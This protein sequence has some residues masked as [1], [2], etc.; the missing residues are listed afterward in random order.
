M[1]SQFIPKNLIGKNDILR[2]E[3]FCQRR[4]QSVLLVPYLS[5]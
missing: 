2:D 1:V 5:G 4:R 3:D